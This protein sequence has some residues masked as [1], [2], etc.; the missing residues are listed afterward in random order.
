MSRSRGSD[1][2]SR[3]VNIGSKNKGFTMKKSISAEQSTGEC[4]QS[5]VL[6]GIVEKV[7]SGLQRQHADSGVPLPHVSVDVPGTH[8]FEGNVVVLD[9]LLN[10]WLCDA[11]RAAAGSAAMARTAEVLITS[12]EYADC[13]EIEIADSGP[14]LVDRQKL[15]GGVVGRVH[16]VAQ[17]NLLDQVHGDIRLDDCAEGG[18][19]VTLRLP[20]VISQRMVA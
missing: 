9:Q 16:T 6:R 18:V 14:S 20:K 5:P 12:V 11:V 15:S 3:L 8:R 13:I 4:G 10:V 17:R 1:D 2:C 7:V 19:A